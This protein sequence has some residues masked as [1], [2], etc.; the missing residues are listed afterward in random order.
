MN[1]NRNAILVYEG[2]TSPEA[3]L[4]L[5]C[6]K[7]K[8]SSTSLTYDILD[9]KKWIWTV[10]TRELISLVRSKQKYTFI[11]S[12][13]SIDAPLSYD[14]KRTIIDKLEEKSEND[15]HNISARTKLRKV[16]ENM[17]SLKVDIRYKT[18]FYG[19]S[20]GL[21]KKSIMTSFKNAILSKND[22]IGFENDSRYSAN[23]DLIKN[24]G[25]K[26]LREHICYRQM[27]SLMI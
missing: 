20:A 1:A 22:G 24:R 2:I 4:S 18:I 5:L 16:A 8:F 14:Y 17:E 12:F 9:V 7:G 26:Y 3:L 19:L 21:D 10:A 25:H 15:E 27:V 13:D 6:I 23:Y 11:K